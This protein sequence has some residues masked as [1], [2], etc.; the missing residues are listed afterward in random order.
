MRPN[1]LD[2]L[3]SNPLEGSPWS[4]IESDPAVFTELLSTIGVKN[5]SVT[6]LLDV[7]IQT[8]RSLPR[9]VHGLVFLFRW[10]DMRRKKKMKVT[11]V[12]GSKEDIGT[13]ID[14]PISIPISTSIPVPVPDVPIPKDLIFINQTTRNACATTALLAICLNSTTLDVGPR[15]HHFRDFCMDLT[16]PL[17]GLAVGSCH[18]L[19]CAHNRF[20]REVDDEVLD[21]TVPVRSRPQTRKNRTRPS[22]QS[23]N[24]KG[25]GRRK[26]DHVDHDH[27]HEPSSTSD[28]ES[29]EG[30]G[31]PGYHF[32]SYLPHAG[33]V[34]EMDGLE[35]TPKRVGPTPIGRDADWCEVVQ[36]VLQRRMGW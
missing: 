16:P 22:A 18:F 31:E 36:P 23:K 26:R 11:D 19:R 17:R 15:L 27:D 7:S 32:I 34:W 33:S 9:P 1:Q 29:E 28:Q 8:F 2:V 6:E 5:A 30:E 35:P 13:V 3:V 10:Q 24:N 21:Y 4:T 20:T 25:R 12:E 14:D